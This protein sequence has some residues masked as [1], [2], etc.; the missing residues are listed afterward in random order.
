MVPNDVREALRKAIEFHGRSLLT[1][2]ERFEAALLQTCPYSRREVELLR[3][4]LAANVPAELEAGHSVPRGT[5]LDTLSGRLRT[6]LLLADTDARWAVDTWAY[7]LG[8]LAPQQ[9]AE[10]WSPPPGAV[11]PPG[12]PYTPPPT[13]G[14]PSW[15]VPGSYPGAPQPGY[16]PTG[17]PVYTQVLKPSRASLIFGL[18]IGSPF[19]CWPLAIIAWVMA[20]NDL[21]DMDRG[22]MDESGRKA[23]T[24]ARKWAIA[25]TCAW[26]SYLLFLAAAFVL[27]IISSK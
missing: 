17:Y 2:P 3:T 26:G 11:Y 25:A 12:S 18:A 19:Y 10:G 24:G 9:P 1:D 13:A 5:L 4:A 20:N 7:A 6:E 14:G 27:A 23:T 15:Q 16:L 21:R 8:L 22:L